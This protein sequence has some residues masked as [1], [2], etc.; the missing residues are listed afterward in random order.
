VLPDN[1]IDVPSGFPTFVPDVVFVSLSASG[2]TVEHRMETITRE[3]TAKANGAKIRRMSHIL[4]RKSAE[5]IPG[6]A[7]QNGKTVKG[8]GEGILTFWR[9]MVLVRHGAGK[10]KNGEGIRDFGTRDLEVYQS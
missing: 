9:F 10:N 4:W 8:N 5:L 1:G 6:V 2:A 7:H 3:M